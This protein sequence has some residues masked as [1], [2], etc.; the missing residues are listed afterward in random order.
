MTTT[1][2]TILAFLL[3]VP[4]ALAAQGVAFFSDLK[5]EVAVDGNA[6][7]NILSEV[8]ETE[9]QR[10]PRF[11]GFDDVSPRP[12]GVSPQGAGRIHREGHRDRRLDHAAGVARHGRR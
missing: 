6:R 12:A 3:A 4:M 11:A 5:G 10:R 1:L 7:P 8:R 9:D 2:R